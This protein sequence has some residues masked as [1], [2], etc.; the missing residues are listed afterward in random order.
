MRDYFYVEDG[1]TAYLTLAEKLAEKPK[2]RGKAFNFSNE[3]QITVLELVRKITKLMGSRLEPDIRD[4]ASNEIPYQNLSAAR[5]RRELGWRPRYTLDEGL[6]A[7]IP[8]YKSFL[9][10]KEA[11]RKKPRAGF[12]RRR[13]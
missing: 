12:A 2:L 1:A 13:R 3:S 5:A 8:W 6:R 11:W 7:T 10:R 4:E 9:E